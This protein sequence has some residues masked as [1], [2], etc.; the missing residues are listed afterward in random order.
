MVER[1]EVIHLIAKEYLANSGLLDQ[2]HELKDKILG[3]WCKP[4]PCHGD[5]LAELANRLD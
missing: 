5:I 3:C 2:I 4:L 1:Q